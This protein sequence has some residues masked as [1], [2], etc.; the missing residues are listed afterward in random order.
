MN[1]LADTAGYPAFEMGHLQPIVQ[2][3]N[4]HLEFNLFYNLD[5]AEAGKV[6]IEHCY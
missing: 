1:N 4:C 6:R 2:N 3:S 5:P